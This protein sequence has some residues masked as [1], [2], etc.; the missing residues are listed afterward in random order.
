MYKTKT[1]SF[2]KL[3]HNL[4]RPGQFFQMIFVRFFLNFDLY[5]AK[6]LQS[7]AYICAYKY[8]KFHFNIT[9]IIFANLV[10]NVTE[11]TLGEL[12]VRCD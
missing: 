9:I 12:A 11:K 10:L 8:L 1:K 2:I 5:S 4:K 7:I 3:L 6:T